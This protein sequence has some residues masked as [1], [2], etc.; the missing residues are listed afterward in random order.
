MHQKTSDKSIEEKPESVVTT[1]S[2]RTSPP[3]SPTDTQPPRKS[4]KTLPPKSLVVE[5]SKVSHI[6]KGK[7]EKVRHSSQPLSPDKKSPTKTSPAAMVTPEKGK[8]PTKPT[9]PPGDQQQKTPQDKSTKTTP[10]SAGSTSPSST[11]V[12][13]EPQ[14]VASEGARVVSESKET[15]KSQQPSAPTP[16][17]DDDF[18]IIDMPSSVEDTTDAA[19]PVEVPVSEYFP[20]AHVVLNSVDWSLTIV[21]NGLCVMIY[22]FQSSKPTTAVKVCVVYVCTCMYMHVHTHARAHTHT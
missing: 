1:P 2:K 4:S 13:P 16:G 17:V 11:P 22:S 9:T 8:T 19:V 5:K 3:V 14:Q 20:V 7:S 10:T 6:S 12:K 18:V 15:D 21:N